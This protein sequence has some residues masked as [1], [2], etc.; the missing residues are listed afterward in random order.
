MP[1]ASF[2]MAGPG[3]RS[4]EVLERLEQRLGRLA[5]PRQLERAQVAQ[6]GGE[7]RGESGTRPA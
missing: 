5:G 6:H 1:G 7:G 2:A 3:K 4:S